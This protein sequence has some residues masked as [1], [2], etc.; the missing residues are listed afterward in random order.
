MTGSGRSRTWQNPCGGGARAAADAIRHNGPDNHSRAFTYRPEVVDQ[1]VEDAENDDQQR[2][3]VLGLES[4]H[5]HDT[6]NAAQGRDQN[7]PE[8]PLA[9][10]DKADKQEDEKNTACKLEVHLS[11]LLGDLRKPCKSLG[12]ANPRVGQNHDKTA[13]D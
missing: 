1:Q 7:A 9:A 11:I 5:H 3:A 12:L 8:R 13:N 2:S 4:N 10:E 6:G